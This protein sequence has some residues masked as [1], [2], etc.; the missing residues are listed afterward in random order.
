MLSQLQAVPVPRP[1]S[2]GDGGAKGDA[3]ALDQSDPGYPRSD[4]VGG[5]ATGTP[6]ATSS[7]EY[8]RRELAQSTAGPRSHSL[9]VLEERESEPNERSQGQQ[10]SSL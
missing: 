10:E 8:C 1:G 5:G 6:D 4:Q 3:A 7:L 2:L 9:G